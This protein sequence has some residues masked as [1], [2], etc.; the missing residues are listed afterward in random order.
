MVRQRRGRE[1][2]ELKKGVCVSLDVT[3]FDGRT[4]RVTGKLLHVNEHE[5]FVETDLGN[6]VGP[7]DSVEVEEPEEICPFCHATGDQCTCRI[8]DFMD[9]VPGDR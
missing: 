1:G 5:A 6:V 4:S 8:E 7:R 9:G 3:W 2:D